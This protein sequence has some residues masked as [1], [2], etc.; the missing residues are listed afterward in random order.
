MIFHR[1]KIFISH[2]GMVLNIYGSICD[3]DE[4]VASSDIRVRQCGVRR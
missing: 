2:W 1:Y 4:Y 3:Y